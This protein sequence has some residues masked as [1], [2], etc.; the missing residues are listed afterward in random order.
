MSNNKI[1]WFVAGFVVGM[2]LLFGSAKIVGATVLPDQCGQTFSYW[3][4]D[5]ND[6]N[7]STETGN[8]ND[9]RVVI[10]FSDFINQSGT[11]N[12][13]YRKV[14]VTPKTGYEIVS[15]QLDVQGDNVSGYVTH[16]DK[17]PGTYDPSGNDLIRGVKVTVKKVCPDAC[18]LVEGFQETGP[19]ASSCEVGT[20][21][22]DT[23]QCVEE[24]ITCESPKVLVENECVDPEPQECPEGQV[25]TYPECHEPE[26][27]GGGSS[28]NDSNEEGGI[29]GGSAGTKENCE[30]YLKGNWVLVPNPYQGGELVWNCQ[31]GGST[32]GSAVTPTVP[33][34]NLPYTGYSWYQFLVDGFTAKNIL[35]AGG[36]ALVGA[37]AF[38]WWKRRQA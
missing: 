5:A 1:V 11:D 21:N 4:T 9:S 22:S 29:S 28:N 17:F 34:S 14:T 26:S 20:W 6:G 16:T 30:T 32:G 35:I 7:N 23:Q 38:V 36:I 31:T 2:T 25:G 18:P 12:D 33:L 10:T 3:Q 24:P 15:V 13:G 8:V 19:C 37:L 27:N